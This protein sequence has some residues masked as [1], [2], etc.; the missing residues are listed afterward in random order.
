LRGEHAAGFALAAGAGADD[1]VVLAGE[2]GGEELREVFGDVAAVAVCEDEDF[3]LWVGGGDAG[4]N[5]LSVAAARFGDDASSGLLRVGGGGV[6]AAVVDEDDFIDTGLT[7]AADD[8][9]DGVGFVEGG[10]DDGGDRVGPVDRLKPRSQTRDLG[11]PVLWRVGEDAGPSTPL[12]CHPST[13]ERVPGALRFGRDDKFYA[14]GWG[15][16]FGG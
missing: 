9:G 4:S 1:E 8:V 12:R 13:Q 3:S 14:G 2:D 6:G 10:D 16:H 5:G 15:T 11:H 7:K